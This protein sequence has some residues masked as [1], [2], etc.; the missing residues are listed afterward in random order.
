MYTDPSGEIGIPGAIG[1]AAF[2]IGMQ[3]LICNRLGGDL[4][5][6]F[7]CINLVDV[8]VSGMVGF[9]MPTWLGNVGIPMTMRNGLVRRVVNLFGMRP[10]MGQIPGLSLGSTAKLAA[11]G[12]AYG[13]VT[14]SILPSRQ[15][16]CEDV[17]AQYRWS[18][19]GAM[20]FATSLF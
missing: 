20:G 10:E 14:K 12:T 15:I 3:M 19:T 18:A 4:Y 2:S 6:C 17:C 7:K 11:S 5:T 9:F 16:E 1:G 13:T 8:V